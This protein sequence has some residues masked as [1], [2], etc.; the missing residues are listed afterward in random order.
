MEKNSIVALLL[1]LLPLYGSG[2]TKAKSFVRK[3]LFTASG[4]LAGGIMAAHS[5]QNV[6]IISGAEYFMERRISIKADIYWFLPDY[7]FEGQ[8]QKN[9]NAFMGAAFHFPRDRWD[10]YFAFQPGMAFPGLASGTNTSVTKPGAEPVLLASLGLNYFI[11]QNFHMFANAGYL[12]GNYF[13]E[14]T[15]SFLLD[16]LRIT[17]GLG[18][19]VFFNRYEPYQRKRVRF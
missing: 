5:T 12:H 11:L 14:E 7:Y 10:V 8:L 16:E 15:S 18:F 9:T 13:P 4:G 1:V 3:D 19:N 2:Q 17:A 6:Y